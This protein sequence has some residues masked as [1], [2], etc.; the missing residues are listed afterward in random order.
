[1]TELAVQTRTNNG[2]VA[3]I[4]KPLD[5]LF[6]VTTGQTNFGD[7][8][9]YLYLAT[10]SS[11]P[12]SN[13]LFGKIYNI[14]LDDQKMY[15]AS[16][17][18]VLSNLYE[19]MTGTHPEQLYELAVREGS[20]EA[21]DM[22]MSRGVYNN[23]VVFYDLIRNGQEKAALHLFNHNEVYLDQNSW[24]DILCISAANSYVQIAELA[25]HKGANVNS[26]NYSKSPIE[27]AVFNNQFAMVKLLKENG[28]DISDNILFFAISDEHLDSG[29]VPYLLENCEVDIDY[30][31]EEGGSTVLMRSISWGNTKLA[32]HLI[33]YN[34]D[35]NI[36]KVGWTPLYAALT[37]TEIDLAFSLMLHGANLK[38]STINLLFK[39]LSTTNKTEKDVSSVL[40]FML[41]KGNYTASQAQDVQDN[42]MSHEAKALLSDFIDDSKVFCD[43]YLVSEQIYSDPFAKDI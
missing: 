17:S 34:A 12:V 41:C 39:T 18:T 28:A 19:H 32:Q 14:T 31:E 37:T 40:S 16:L 2:I 43:N 7:I 20:I 13:K 21:L 23:A 11:M 27:L 5:Y 25:I 22:L 35:V 9:K 8:A 4:L 26:N 38:D 36:G 15:N 24:D 29:V 42:D 1:M 3:T 10:T 6:F 33:K 30:R